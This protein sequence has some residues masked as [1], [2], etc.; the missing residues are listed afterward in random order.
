LL[1]PV[2]L[3]IELQMDM[4]GE[5]IEERAGET[6]AAEDAGPFLEWEI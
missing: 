5:A 4:V 6:R 3:A 2:A 1:K